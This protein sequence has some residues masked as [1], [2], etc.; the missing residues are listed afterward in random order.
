MD[1]ILSY[2]DDIDVSKNCYY[3]NSLFLYLVVP[4][5]RIIFPQHGQKIDNCYPKIWRFI[6]S[7]QLETDYPDFDFCKNYGENCL[8]SNVS[9]LQ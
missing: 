3:R 8:S 2:V 6:K 1:E 4:L 5:H 9:I 7:C